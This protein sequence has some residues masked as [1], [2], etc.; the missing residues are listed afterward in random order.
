MVANGV[1]VDIKTGKPGNE[2]PEVKAAEKQDTTKG[3]K[4]E[5]K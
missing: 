4:K 1:V 2:E 5:K 3:S